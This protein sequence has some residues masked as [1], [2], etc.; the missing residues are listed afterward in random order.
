MKSFVLSS[1]Y[2]IIALAV[3]FILDVGLYFFLNEL[4]FPALNWF[5]HI[6]WVLKLLVLFFG[7]VT[8]FFVIFKILLNAG[9][10]IGE[11]IFDRF[12]FNL[13]ILVST[14]LIAIANSIYFIILIWRVPEHYNFWIV[15]ELIYLS[16][17]IYSISSLIVPKKSK[18]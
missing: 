17:F 7:G 15:I 10:K 18:I 8:L 9:I 1:I 5:N 3:L 11:L 6:H 14:I 12:P 2:L 16:I 13:F 4:V